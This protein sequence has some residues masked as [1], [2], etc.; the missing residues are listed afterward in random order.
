MASM[1]LMREGFGDTEL[2]N[3]YHARRIQPQIESCVRNVL[4]HI[5]DSVRTFSYCDFGSADGASSSII[6]RTVASELKRA[7]GPQEISIALEDQPGN[8]FRPAFA[9]LIKSLQ[10][11]DIPSFVRSIG[12][13]FY[14]QCL[15]TGS[16]HFGTSNYATFYLDTRARNAAGFLPGYSLSLLCRMQ[17]AGGSED[18][19]SDNDRALIAANK[20][21]SVLDW[22]RFLLNRAK[23]LCN[24]GRLLVTSICTVPLSCKEYD[25]HGSHL[26]RSV[27]AELELVANAVHDMIAEGEINEG[28]ADNCIYPAHYR[29]LEEVEAPFQS[30]DSRVRRAGL[31]LVRSEMM[32]AEHPDRHVM[33]SLDQ[34]SEEEVRRL[35]DKDCRSIQSYFWPL[36]KK[37]LATK[38]GRSE[39]EAER[40]ANLV[41]ARVENEMLKQKRFFVE[42]A[43]TVIEIEKQW[44]EWELQRKRSFVQLAS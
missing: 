44:Q 32:I 27:Q 18:A 23:E 29:T 16:L 5:P 7:R 35:V 12:T 11:V 24:G 40:L 4:E 42:V 38:P 41:F 43:L 2:V 1:Y 20:E 6:A 8:D 14:D 25:Q 17:L 26:F 13:S 9:R 19:L 36:V 15:P 3:P 39:E 37:G 22:E 33:N 31:R 30:P 10:N 28:E 21:R 34:L